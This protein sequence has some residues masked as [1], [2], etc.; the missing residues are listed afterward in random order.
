MGS[1]RGS[2][3]AMRPMLFR[4]QSLFIFFILFSY[5]ASFASVVFSAEQ[6]QIGRKIIR[7][8][9]ADSDEE[10]ARGL[11]Y[12]RG[13]NE[14]EG[15]L[16]V[17]PREQRL[18]FWMKNTFIDLSIA[19][20]S[21]EKQLIEIQEM[22]AAKSEMQTYFESYISARPAQYA[23]EMRRGWFSK[24]GIKVGDKLVFPIKK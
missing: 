4:D 13:L 8:E 16:F 24:N 14:N 11:M 15:M 23:L 6:I 2:L 18:S 10:R 7:V 21:K 1:H 17:F 22:K 9:I 12:R 20:F 5:Q 19:F 3:Q